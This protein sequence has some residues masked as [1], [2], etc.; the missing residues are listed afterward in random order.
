M[1]GRAHASRF[2]DWFHSKDRTFHFA[3]LIQA[4]LTSLRQ[5]LCG[6]SNMTRLLLNPSIHTMARLRRRLR[7]VLNVTQNAHP[8]PI[9]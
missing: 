1:H 6:L 3:V 5:D 7:R 2:L 8:S 4:Q 9:K